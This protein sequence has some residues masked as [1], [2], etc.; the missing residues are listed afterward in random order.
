MQLVKSTRSVSF[1][2]AYLL[3]VCS[4]YM[5]HVVHTKIV[6]GLGYLNL[7]LGIEEGIGELFTFSQ[8]ALNDLEARYIA[9]KVSNRL[10]WVVSGGVGVRLGLDGGEA[11]VSFQ[12]KLVIEQ[13]KRCR[14]THHQHHWQL[15]W[16]H[17]KIH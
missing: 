4:S 2:S 9:Q 6:Q 8:S 16:I 1:K 3:Y 10:V 11:W 5:T 7:L 14:R 12:L 15:H 13:R 17:W